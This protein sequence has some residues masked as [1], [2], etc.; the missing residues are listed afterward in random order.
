MEKKDFDVRRKFKLGKI[1]KKI[2]LGSTLIVF[3]TIVLEGISYY[4][5]IR[6]G[7][8]FTLF[9]ST[10]IAF[11]ISLIASD[12]FASSIIYPVKKLH[13]ATTEVGKGN[14]KTKVT[15]NTNDELNE[16]GDSF[17]K[18]TEE[19]ARIDEEYK[20]I[21]RAK[22]EFLSITSHELRSPMTPMKAQLQ[23]L[24]EGYFGKI[25]QKQ[26]ESIGMV[27]R[28][29]NR[30]DNIILDFLEISR[31]ETARLKFRFVETD[32]KENIQTLI[33]EMKDYLPQKK[34][35]IISKIGKLPIIEADPDRAMQVL[36]NLLNNAKKFSL[37]KGIIKV[38]AELQDKCIL[39]KVKDKGI[40]IAPEFQNR[41]F[42]PFFQEEQT[43]YRKYG[44]NGLGLTICKGI[45]E[46]QGGKIWFESTKGKGST[47]YFTI[48]LKPL[49]E[50]KPIKLSFTSEGGAKLLE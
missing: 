41:V 45:I 27:L 24:I 49:K 9:I 47:F 17:N 50:I 48:P 20:K 37:E 35:Q 6:L 31:I 29:T 36:R 15:I 1:G 28:N 23:M 30:L 14:F 44:G 39:F 7:S 5:A 8:L 19:L 4:F 3:T 2:V 25:N 42:E 18:M 22:T 43:M 34:I 11:A 32:L 13:D 21:D 16:L 40:G 33:K 38:E 10:V 26:K 12:F 46:S